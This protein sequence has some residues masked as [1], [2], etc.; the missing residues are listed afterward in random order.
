MSDAFSCEVEHALT[1]RARRE[2]SHGDHAIIWA[3]KRI[4]ELEAKLERVA[5]WAH[6]GSLMEG[7]ELTEIRK[8]TLPHWNISEFDELLE[9]DDE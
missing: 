2:A 1:R 8:I 4:A 7:D 6:H 9:N 3:S 5:A